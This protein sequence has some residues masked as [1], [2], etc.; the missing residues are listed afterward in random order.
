[1]GIYTILK[2]LN[3]RYTFFYIAIIVILLFIFRNV[4]IGLNILFAIA[5]ALV[6]I[7]YN[8]DKSITTFQIEEEEKREKLDNIQPRPLHIKGHDDILNLFFSIQD[9]YHHNPQAYE[10]TIDNV[11]AFLT[12]YDIVFKNTPFCEYNYQIAESKK[13]NALNALHSIIFSLPDNKL[14]IDKLTRAHKRLETI[15]NIYLNELYDKCHHTL[16]KNGYDIYKRSINLGPREANHYF[17]KD[18]TY[19]LY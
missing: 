11:D 12:I 18:F 7:I 5:I 14:V 19:Q 17:D 8:Y 4:H 15:L 10:E 3:N 1:M 16:I 9:F 13:N 2:D 6:L